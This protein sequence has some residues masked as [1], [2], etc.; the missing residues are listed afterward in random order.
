MKGL[1][2]PSLIVLAALAGP[3]AYAE[4][5][6]Q[7]PTGFTIAHR[8]EVP[9]PPERVFG[10]IGEIGRWWNGAHTYSGSA[11]NLRLDMEAGGCFCE[12]WD[13]GSVEHLRVVSVGRGK[14]VRM[15]GGLG[16]LQMLPVNGVLTIEVSAA[17]E[18]RTALAWTY[19]V[20]G[21]AD[22]ALQ[23]WAAPVDRVIGEQASRLAAYV[24]ATK[25]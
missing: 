9:A 19:R 16:P 3:A 11:A 15:L 6:A 23:E 10:A 2:I 4:V 21:P 7:S 18:G 5:T 17:P 8:A 13:G 1:P 20:A 12:R 24:Q 25:P 14:S 22:A